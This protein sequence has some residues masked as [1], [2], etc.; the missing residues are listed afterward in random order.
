[1]ILFLN[2]RLGLFS[3]L[4]SSPGVPVS[5]PLILLLLLLS[6]ILLLLLTELVGVEVVFLILLSIAGLRMLKLSF[7]PHTG[8]WGVI[9]GQN[10]SFG[11][12][13]A[14]GDPGDPA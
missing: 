14:S 5:T 4:F 8:S 6:L 11:S 2:H 1:M 9:L 10:A 12:F 3:P 7:K 13:A